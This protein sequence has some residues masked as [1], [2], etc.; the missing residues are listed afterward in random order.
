LTAYM[1]EL[2]AALDEINDQLDEDFHAESNRPGT[3]CVRN[4]G[5]GDQFIVDTL[6]PINS[7]IKKAKD[8]I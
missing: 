1:K 2:N 4:D 7:V 3:V 5:T 6:T 8:S